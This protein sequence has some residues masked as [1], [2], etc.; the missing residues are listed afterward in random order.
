MLYKIYYYGEKSNVRSNHN[1]FHRKRRILVPWRPF[2]L[3]FGYLSVMQY[4]DTAIAKELKS[5][6]DPKQNL[7]L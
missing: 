3:L 2:V 5:L 4:A 6:S 1:I 7:I